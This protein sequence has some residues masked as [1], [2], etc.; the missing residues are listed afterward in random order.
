MELISQSGF[1]GDPVFHPE[2]SPIS[3]VD[4]TTGQWNYSY[5]ADYLLIGAVRTQTIYNQQTWTYTLRVTPTSPEAIT[6][7]IKGSIGD[8]RDP[9]S[10]IIGQQGL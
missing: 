2:G 8:K 3:K 6:V 9:S 7:Y 10:G 4:Q 5:P 1:D